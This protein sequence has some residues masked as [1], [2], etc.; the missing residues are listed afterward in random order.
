MQQ[1]ARCRR[2]PFV[3]PDWNRRAKLAAREAEH[4]ELLYVCLAVE[5][6]EVWML[7]LHA[8]DLD[9]AWGE[10]RKEPHPKERFAAP[11]L[12]GAPHGSIGG[13]W[14]WAMEGLNGKSFPT[15]LD[16]CPELRELRARLA[17]VVSRS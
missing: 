16:R 1:F 5:E 7:A 9:V 17:S 4:P 11:L 8:S 6:V 15:L 3:Q 14:R 12:K 10:V 13:G 2:S